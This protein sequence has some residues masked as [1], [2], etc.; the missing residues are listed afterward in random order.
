MHASAPAKALDQHPFVA[1]L[2]QHVDL[3]AADLRSLDAIIDGELLIRRRRDLIVDGVEYHKLSF[4]KEGYAV[5]YKLLRNGKRASAAIF[6][7]GVSSW[8][9]ANKSVRKGINR[10]KPLR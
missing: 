1:R 3:D 5:R 4:V 2:L 7:R 6:S 8:T 9:K 10:T